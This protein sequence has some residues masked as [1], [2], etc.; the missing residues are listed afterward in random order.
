MVMIELV[1]ALVLAFGN[2]GAIPVAGPMANPAN[3]G[4]EEVDYQRPDKDVQ[5]HP[6]SWGELKKRYN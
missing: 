6:V 5:P 2:G 3:P 4:E 1:I